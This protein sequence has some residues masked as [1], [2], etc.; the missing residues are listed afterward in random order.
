MN[1]SN[2]SKSSTFTIAPSGSC[3]A[4]PPQRGV[5]TSKYAVHASCLQEYLDKEA[6]KDDTL[7]IDL[8]PVSEFSKSRIKGSVNLSLPATLIKR[9][10]FS[11]ARIISNLHDVD[12]KR[13][14]QNWQEFSSILVCVPAWIAN[15]VT[16]AEV[17]GE[18]FRKESYSGD[19]GILDLDYS[20]VSGKYPS[21]IDNSPVKSKLGALPSARPR[22]S[23]SAAQTAPISLSSEGSDYFSRPPPTPNVA[24]LSLNNFFCPLPENKDNK[25]SPF[26]SATVQTPCL[27]SVPDAFTNPDVATLYQKFLRLQSLEH[28]RLVSCSDR[29]S[30]WSTV[31]SL[32]N[33]S[34]KKNRYTDIVPY[35][36]TRVHL[37]RTSPSELDYIN[38]SF[39]KTETSNYI[40][41]QGSISRSISDF[42]HMV[43]D[44]V[45]NIGTIVML[46][47]L[48]EAGREMCTAYWPSNGI[49]DKQVYGDYCVK[50]ISEENVDNSR[51]ILRKFEIQNAN[52]PSVKKVHHYQYPNWSDCNSPENVK[53]MVEFLKYVNNSHGS[54]NTIVH[55]SAGV[56]RTGTFIVLDTILRFPESKLSGFNP[57]VADSSDVVF[58]LVDHI[59]KQRMKMVQTFT[60]FKYVYDLI[61]SL[62]KS[63]VHFPVLT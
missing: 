3:I 60:Q 13:D 4:L 28:Q 23:Y 15:Y 11:V 22:L 45:E 29:N 14:F 51:F 38:A 55:C 54:G 27:H 32:S 12:D 17:I 21:V 30:Q 53:S 35:N 36:C 26:G 34:Y 8:R 5:A 52:F 48:F 40:A 58:Q 7:I 2:G 49:G 63:Q 39:I 19:F 24:G 1:F 9:P 41:C 47:S 33:T 6:W 42:W 44:N 37:K 59:R 50:Q 61:D 46:G 56:G 25:S 62:Q 16:N 57:S 10:A 31:D 43:W 20:K 18:K